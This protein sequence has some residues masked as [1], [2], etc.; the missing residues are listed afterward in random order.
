[1]LA[2]YEVIFIGI[3]FGTQFILTGCIMSDYYKFNIQNEKNE[4]NEKN[5]DK[6]HNKT[7]LTL[8]TSCYFII[9]AHYAFI[10][11]KAELS[12]GC[13][14]VAITSILYHGFSLTVIERKIIDVIRYIDIIIS[15]ACIGWFMISHINLSLEYLIA[16]LAVLY[17]Y[18]IYIHYDLTSHLKYGHIWHATIH[19]ASNIGIF[20]LII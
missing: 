17:N 3:I 9:N 7:L 2:P 1:M 11:N 15:T 19:I 12:Y 6:N 4:K 5:K 8:V 13:D 10:K 18:I 14:I 20:A 16:L